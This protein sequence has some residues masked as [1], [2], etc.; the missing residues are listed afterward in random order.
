ML[1]PCTPP[2]I[3]SANVFWSSRPCP[4]QAVD[5][6]TYANPAV[7]RAWR[8]TRNEFG[9][10]ARVLKRK[11]CFQKKNCAFRN[12]Y[13]RLRPK[14]PATATGQGHP[15]LSLQIHIS[16]CQCPSECHALPVCRRRLRRTLGCSFRGF[17]STAA[18]T[19]AQYHAQCRRRQT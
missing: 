15:A 16:P 19:S 3:F 6:G 17:S 18:D 12:G 9:L 2:V 4:M 10:F 14:H 13:K 1:G 7:D 11:L 5:A 8:E